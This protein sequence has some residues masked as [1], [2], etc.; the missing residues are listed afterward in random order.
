M[1]SDCMARLNLK[2]RT[3]DTAADSS[4]RKVGPALR[5]RIWDNALKRWTASWPGC[6]RFMRRFANARDASLGTGTAIVGI[7]A[8]LTALNPREMPTGTTTVP[9][10]VALRAMHAG[11]A[12]RNHTP[13]TFSMI[14]GVRVSIAPYDPR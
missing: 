11:M 6:E 10:D 13:L 14:Y 3:H 8:V 7:V 2:V 12:A 5:S 4:E 1:A 9:N